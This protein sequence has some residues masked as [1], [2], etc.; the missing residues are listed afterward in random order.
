VG[1]FLSIEGGFCRLVGFEGV[2]VF[3]EEQP[4]S[5]LGVV[6]FAGAPGSFQRTSSMFLKAC[7]NMLGLGSGGL[8]VEAGRCEK[9][10]AEWQS[11]LELRQT[12][13][14]GCGDRG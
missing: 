5:L 10:M 1:V 9:W 13:R 3:Q 12:I 6:E 14:K 8:E 7:S 4:R 2:E 11:W